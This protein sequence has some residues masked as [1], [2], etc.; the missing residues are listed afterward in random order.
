MKTR[1]TFLIPVEQVA[2]ILQKDLQTISL[3]I[4]NCA[5]KWGAAVLIW[6]LD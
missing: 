4:T 2:V 6:S 5:K 1:V 3:V